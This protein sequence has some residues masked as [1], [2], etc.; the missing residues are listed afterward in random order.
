MIACLECE[1]KQ[2]AVN[3]R[4]LRTSRPSSG[5]ALG[6]V[7]P[8]LRNS[9]SPSAIPSSAQVRQ[10]YVK[11]SVG[12]LI[13]S[14]KQV[15]RLR[16][17]VN[18]ILPY[19]SNGPPSKCCPQFPWRKA[20]GTHIPSIC[21][22]VET[23]TSRKALRWVEGGMPERRQG[24][25]QSRGDGLAQRRTILHQNHRIGRTNLAFAQPYQ[26]T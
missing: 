20:M 11:I 12:A 9:Y 7:R 25:R 1:V 23:P 14:A 26:T 22:L 15:K 3:M 16:E 18:L 21:D 2:V 24:A 13:E 4:K 19:S 10:P 8:P 6:L 5:W 17:E